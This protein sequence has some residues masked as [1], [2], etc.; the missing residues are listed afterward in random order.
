MEFLFHKDLPSLTIAV[1]KAAML[2]LRLHDL[3]PVRSRGR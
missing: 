1:L 2:L 3:K